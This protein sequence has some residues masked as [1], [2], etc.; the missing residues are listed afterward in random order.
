MWEQEA[1]SLRENKSCVCG[2]Y[3]EKLC[4]E[5]EGLACLLPHSLHIFLR[6]S[7][8]HIY[9]FVIAP[10]NLQVFAFRV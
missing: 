4:V 6:I 3:V 9:K 1:A 2:A 7:E 10:V 5:Q 8:K